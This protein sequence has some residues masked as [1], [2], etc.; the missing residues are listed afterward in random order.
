MRQF[1]A[2]FIDFCLSSTG[3]SPAS[4]GSHI[5]RSYG[6]GHQYSKARMAQPD[7]K[8]RAAALKIIVCRLASLPGKDTILRCGA[9]LP[10][11]KPCN[12]TNQYDNL[13]THTRE[14]QDPSP[15]T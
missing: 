5:V 3:S 15:R 10:T 11:S 1:L 14:N 6:R 9:S 2:Q 7:L 13:S 8:P 12:P 4:A